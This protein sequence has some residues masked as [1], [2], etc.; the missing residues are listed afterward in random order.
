MQDNDLIVDYTGDRAGD[1][2]IGTWDGVAY[3]G[4]TGLI[5]AGRIRSTAAIDDPGGLTALAVAEAAD[6]L[7]LAGGDT[8]LWGF[9]TVDATSVLVK[10]SYVGDADLSGAI[11]A[12]DYGYIDNY[13]QFPGA[14]GYANG[15][16]NYDGIIDAADYGAIDN[17]IQLQG[18]P[19]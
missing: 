12:V 4:I 8:A 18:P 16:F 6:V 7:G 3:D 13:V 9:Q 5:A 1:S 15:D 11:D 14:F 17:S 10:Y 2:V 19:L